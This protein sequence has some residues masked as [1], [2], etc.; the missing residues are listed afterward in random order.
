MN[1]LY[2]FKWPVI[3]SVTGFLI[4]VIGAMMKILHWQDADQ[5]LLIATAIIVAGLLFLIVKLVLVKNK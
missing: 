5:V 1:V 2:K 4:R 3:I